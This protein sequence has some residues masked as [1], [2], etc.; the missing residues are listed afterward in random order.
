MALSFEF[1]VKGSAMYINTMQQGMQ[2]PQFITTVECLGNA[3]MQ[4]SFL[5]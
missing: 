3:L 4:A 1:M 2:N 5:S